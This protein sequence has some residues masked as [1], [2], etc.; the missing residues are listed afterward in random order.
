MLPTRLLSVAAAF[1]VVE[2]AGAVP[3]PTSLGSSLT[4][5]YQNNLD[6]STAPEH[7][8][9][10]LLSSSSPNA[11]AAA[12][13]A[14]LGETLLDATGK[15]ALEDIR[16]Q[17]G[18]LAY[19]KQV[20][21]LQKFWVA[22]ATK[23]CNTIDT[24]GVVRQVSCSL[25]FPAL[26]SQSAPLLPP[27][28]QNTSARFQTTVKSGG[29][30]FTGYRD[31]LSFRFLGVR[32]GNTPARWTYST[33]F[34][35][36][37]QS[38]DNTVK[39]DQCVQWGGGSEDCLF[40]NIFSPYLPNSSA[41]RDLR[42]VV[43][44]IHGGAFTGG[45]ANDLTFDGGSMSS[46]NDVVVVHINYR[47]STLGFLALDDG[48]TKGN[49]GISDQ[50]TALEWVQ[51]HI[52][53]F[54]GDPARV[55]IVGQSAGAA[56]TRILLGSPRAIGKFAAAI[57]MSNLA[58]L[59]YATTYSNY[60][61]IP[62]AVDLAT[63]PILALTG[64]NTT[65]SPAETLACLR[66]VDALTLVTLS[67]TA[68]YPVVDGNFIPSDQLPVTGNGPIAHVPV[69]MGFMRDDGA[70][71]IGYPSNDNLTQQVTSVLPAPPASE[72]IA[73]GLFNPPSTA[74]ATLD[75]FNV[76]ARL[77]TDFQFRCLDQASVYS[78]QKRGLLP[79]L[80]LYQFDRSYQTAGWSPNGGV[81]E[82]PKDVEHPNGDP[83]KEYFKC[84][85][86]ELYYVWGTLGVN[87][88]PFRD[89]LDLPFSQFVTD[90]WG[91]FF[92]KHDPNPDP[93]LLAVRGYTSTLQQLAKAGRWAPVTPHNLKLRIFDT[94]S[95][96]SGFRN[97][98]NASY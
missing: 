60:L 35:K 12:A 40:L 70:A 32:Y 44:H 74:N 98:T 34:S 1:L 7:Q 37:G 41:T 45:T 13:C 43:V 94:P 23:T 19:R 84:H 54:G 67:T 36:T 89:A 56:S 24:L 29:N 73:S 68:R 9:A 63:K 62:Q 4:F 27:D 91:A 14:A 21:L 49:F 83:S 80:W 96:I 16:A 66:G 33:V 51:G 75:V 88:R 87:A 50:V 28:A 22:S 3:S 55:T 93:A 58:G 52:R 8:A 82:P 5:L 85:S 20:A 90:H 26:C 78:S 18:Y 92:H 17:L 31:S 64:C 47:L 81:C 97:W 46:R 10:V 6:W 76:T 71:M 25:S 53:D 15:H 2:T 86:G 30:T 38:F 48:V 79:K 39:G 72:V 77:A 61:T 57:P 42:P 69:L 95:R 11:R 65:T 59:G